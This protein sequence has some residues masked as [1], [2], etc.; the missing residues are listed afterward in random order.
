MSEHYFFTGWML[1][2]CHQSTKKYF[3]LSLSHY[4]QK[5]LNSYV[6]QQKHASK[7]AAMLDDIKETYINV[8]Q[9]QIRTKP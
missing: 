3:S 6:A 8:A 9:R 5:L 1:Y 2:Q 4:H 7:S